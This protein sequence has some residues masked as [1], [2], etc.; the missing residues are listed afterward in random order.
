MCDDSFVSELQRALL[1]LYDPVELSQSPLQA[2]L[3]VAAARNPTLALQQV[4]LDSIQALRPSETVPPHANAWRLYH[5]LTYRYVEQLSQREI[6]R[7]LAISI[8]QLRRQEKAAVR[9]LADYLW[10]HYDLG[11]A[12]AAPSTPSVEGEPAT[13]GTAATPADAVTQESELRWL[14]ESRPSEIVSIASLVA[15]ASNTVSPLADSLDV[16]IECEMPSAAAHARGPSSTMR[17]TLVNLLSAVIQA[18]PGG[19]LDIAAQTGPDRIE[20]LV[21]GAAGPPGLNLSS[22]EMADLVSM[23][24]QL[25]ALYGG[26]IGLVAERHLLKATLTVPAADRITVLVVDDNADALQLME[27][28]LSETRYVFVGTSDPERAVSLAE[29]HSPQIIV[30]DV[31]LPGIDGWELLGRFREHP[32]T[33]TVPVIICTILPQRQLALTLGAAGFLRKPLS[34]ETLLSELDRQV[35]PL[36]RG[37]CSTRA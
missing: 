36:S 16:D 17:Q 9:V 7:D 21:Q 35:F 27:R 6:G 29:E 1:H 34:R 37:S 23:A 8:R 15:A 10:K 4:L 30:M 31:M 25:A 2:L 32:K 13:E 11:R 14:Q 3:G 22:V 5:L 24:R 12:V 28:Y 33:R 19:Q 20:V 18:V 26:Q